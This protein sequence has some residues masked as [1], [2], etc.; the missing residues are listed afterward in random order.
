MNDYA[1]IKESCLALLKEDAVLLSERYGV[2]ALGVFGSVARG[3]DKSASD[4]NILYHFADDRGDLEEFIGL[5]NHLELL[6][7]REIDLISCDYICEK[8]AD[9]ISHD[10]IFI[11]D[12][13]GV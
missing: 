9:N 2:D 1:S 3:E 11:F 12:R 4:I 6:F 7:K 5:K 8:K 10:V 13:R